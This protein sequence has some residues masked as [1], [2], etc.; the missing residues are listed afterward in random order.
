MAACDK[1]LQLLLANRIDTLDF[2]FV[3]NYIQNMP[4]HVLLFHSIFRLRL[5]IGA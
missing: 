5:L 2:Y 1:M 3:D 4:T